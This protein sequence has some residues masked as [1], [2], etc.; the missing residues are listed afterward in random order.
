MAV[1]HNLSEYINTSFFLLFMYKHIK[2]F[3]LPCKK[4]VNILI[5]LNFDASHL[6]I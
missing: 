4:L 6:V 2:R 5:I 3:T 1:G